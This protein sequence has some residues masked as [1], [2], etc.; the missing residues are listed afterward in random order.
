M[1]SKTKELTRE[2]ITSAYLF[3]TNT[4]MKN[5]DICMYELI[6]Y[7]LFILDMELLIFTFCFT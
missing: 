1:Q 7:R 2:R 3:T 5:D 6:S 4:P